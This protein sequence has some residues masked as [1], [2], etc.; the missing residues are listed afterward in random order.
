MIG[1]TGQNIVTIVCCFLAA[2]LT[3]WAAV[4]RDKATRLWV[5]KREE[6]ARAREDKR[7]EEERRIEAE[8]RDA[9]RKELEKKRQPTSSQ[10][11]ILDWC[12]ATGGETFLVD[13]SDRNWTVST[14]PKDSTR[15]QMTFDVW[16]AD[17][18]ALEQKQYIEVLERSQTR[19]PAY[20]R[21]FRLKVD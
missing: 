13:G 1:L 16:Q 10:M 3:H 14:K 7:R 5:E 2:V 12:K 9:E 17:F 15:N 19:H 20:I 8:K 18:D 4:R 6:A 11:K 21:Q